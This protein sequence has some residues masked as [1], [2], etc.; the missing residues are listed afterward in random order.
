MNAYL[1][2][3]NSPRV[4]VGLR[5]SGKQRQIDCLID[6]GFSS[7]LALNQSLLKRTGFPVVAQQK[8]ELADG[9]QVVFDVYLATV[10]FGEKKRQLRIV[11]TG[12]EAP[13]LDS[14]GFSPDEVHWSGIPH[15]KS[16][17]HRFT[18]VAFWCA[19]KDNIVG[20]EFLDGLE[21]NLNLKNHT[22]SLT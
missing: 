17:I 2:P 3:N 19:G 10:E 20:L 22:I 6:T 5:I 13:R 21:F 11:F 18:P 12:S 4:K 8:F 9:S 15:R 1:T 16:F 14:R 7:G